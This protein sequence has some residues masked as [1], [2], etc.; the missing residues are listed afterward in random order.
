MSGARIVII[1]AGIA[2]LA[3]AA[4]LHQ[5]GMPCLVFEQA[6]DLR[7]L[8]AG[9]QISPNAVRQ[10]HRLGL[11][12]H[13]RRDAVPIQ[14]LA[15]FRWSDDAPLARMPLGERATAAFGAPYYAVHR[16]DLHHALM[17]RI[18]QDL[19]ELGARCTG[20]REREGGVRAHFADGRHADAD[21]VVG[22][23]GIHSV[24]RA[25][26]ATDIPRYTGH[27]IYRGLV[28]ADRCPFPTDVPQVRLWLG[29]D[30]HV[31][32]YPISAGRLVYFGATATVERWAHQEWSVPAEVGELA[33]MYTGWSG[34]VR[35]LVSAAREVT[36]WALHDR[37]NLDRWSSARTTLAGDA[38][39]PM[40]PFMAQ[41]ANQAVED[42]AV[43]AGCLREAPRHN[44]GPALQRYEG[45]RK[46]RI[47][48]V[49]TLSSANA[50]VFHLADG[51]A[52]R[53]RDTAFDQVWSIDRLE[54]LFGHD[55][56]H[57]PTRRESA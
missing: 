29:P 18:P 27:V 12:P 55:A 54:W 57:L 17:T 48:Q 23:D 47:Q 9:I 52:Q 43:L 40:L 45:I 1:G 24:V 34:T 30:Q 3:A 14:S 16:A 32:C 25:C 8:G 2:G 26:V 19:V 33:R 39:H 11:E 28:D 22:T 46:P 21:V 13:L 31:V 41:A 44:P 10:L 35:A 56:A 50:E 20:V 51:P 42:A 49:H 15:F 38:A 53:A 5:A 36:C 37:D 6:P 4:S 7:A